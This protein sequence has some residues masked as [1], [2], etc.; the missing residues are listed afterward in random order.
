[1]SL[2]DLTKGLFLYCLFI[3]KA[4]RCPLKVRNVGEGADNSDFVLDMMRLRCLQSPD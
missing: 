2:V 3:F 1:M 4:T